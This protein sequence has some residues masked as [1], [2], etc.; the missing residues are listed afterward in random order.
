MQMIDLEDLEVYF[1]TLKN[2]LKISEYIIYN[3]IKKNNKINL[4]FLVSFLKITPKA[5]DI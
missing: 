4:I 1:S 2:Y 5:N 3:I